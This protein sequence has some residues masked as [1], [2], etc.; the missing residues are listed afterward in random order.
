MYIAVIWYTLSGRYIIDPS[1]DE[2]DNERVFL[3]K[4]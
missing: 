3:Y 4:P 2:Y 1:H